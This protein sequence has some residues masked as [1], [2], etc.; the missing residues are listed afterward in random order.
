M[1]KQN[2]GKRIF[3]SL[4]VLAGGYALYR[5]MANEI[6]DEQREREQ[7]K[8]WLT[9]VKEEIQENVKPF[10]DLT[11][12]EYDRIAETAAYH[13]GR[14]YHVNAQ[15]FSAAMDDLRADWGRVRDHLRETVEKS[16]RKIKNRIEESMQEDE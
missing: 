8:E 11:E 6:T 4:V 15:E 2:V 9:R 13:Y 3:F 16:K 14:I 7:A 5:K 12:K 1:T 10:K